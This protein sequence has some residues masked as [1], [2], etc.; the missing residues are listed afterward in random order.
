MSV[1]PLA[2]FQKHTS[3]LYTISRRVIGGRGSVILYEDNAMRV[4]GLYSLAPT[5]ATV[6]QM[7]VACCYRR[8]VVA[9]FEEGVAP[10]PSPSPPWATVL[11]ICDDCKTCT[12]EYSKCHHPVAF[13]SF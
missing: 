4:V 6:V 11:L 3:E 9:D 5:S 2:C 7:R 10:A 1:C 8:S 12:S 13:S